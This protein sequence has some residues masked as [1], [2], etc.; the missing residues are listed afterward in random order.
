[1][2]ISGL[3]ATSNIID[4]RLLG[5]RIFHLVGSV[6]AT[7]NSLT[8]QNGNTAVGDGGGFY[9]PTGV[10]S[11]LEVVI[12]GNSALYAGGIYNDGT[13]EVR[14][15]VIKENSGQSSGGVYNL[16]TA[17]IDNSDIN[18]N[19]GEFSNAQGGKITIT[20]STISRSKDEQAIF[21]ADD[22]V[23]IIASS[24]V[25]SNT[26]AIYSA[27][28]LEVV[29][30]TVR[31]NS[32]YGIL[33]IRGS[34]LVSGSLITDNEG[35]AAI[36]TGAWPALILNSTIS[37]NVGEFGGGITTSGRTTIYGSIITGNTSKSFSGLGG[38][39]VHSGGSYLTIINTTISDNKALLNGGGIYN[40]GSSPV[41][42]YN[43]TLVNNVAD[44]DGN[45]SGDGGGIFNSQDFNN[46]VSLMNTIVA[47]NVDSGGQGND[48]WGVLDSQD[49]NL[50][51]DSVGCTIQG[52]VSHNLTGVDPRLGSLQDNGGPT[53]THALLE[54]SPAIDAGNP[55]GC[56]Y[57][58]GNILGFDQRG[59]FRTKDGDGDTVPNC[60]MGS[61]EYGSAAPSN[62]VYLP[63]ICSN[64]DG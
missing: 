50:I 20:N 63:F 56:T 43:V 55:L 22:T 17:T 48:C 5:D 46:T 27:G 62:F 42:L 34:L 9:N 14:D 33:A 15:S 40:S 47:Q 28:Q 12:T 57:Y 52:I 36:N 18:N 51:Q 49:Y 30:S 59:F 35:G 25:M 6:N 38:G 1:V 4:G 10:L 53:L 39:G 11:L 2:T 3:N 21:N 61:Y 26:I 31:N 24:T 44:S 58:D 23:M 60:D 64:C 32:D 54:N 19:T 41:E 29:N 7:I 37:N 16:G 45:G 13:L 8:V